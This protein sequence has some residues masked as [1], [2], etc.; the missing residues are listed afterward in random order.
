MI[1]SVYREDENYYPKVF[2][3]K[4]NFNDDIE[5]YPDNSHNGDS[6]EEY[7]D[8][9]DD[10]VEE[11]KMNKILM[12][13]VKCIDIFSEKTSILISRHPEMHEVFISQSY[14]DKTFILEN[15]RNP[16]I[17]IFFLLFDLWIKN[18]PVSSILLLQFR[19]N[20]ILFTLRHF[21]L[22]FWPWC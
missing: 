2:L 15:I 12:K 14:Q 13:K 8:D 5:I 21:K 6:H 7:S 20:I 4:Y 16:S 19:V 11:N 3:E 18:V 10:S 9:S 17:V 22:H 1:D